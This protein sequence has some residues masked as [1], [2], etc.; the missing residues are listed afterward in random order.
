MEIT[1]ILY[2]LLS[3]FVLISFKLIF[4]QRTRFKNL[5]PSPPSLPIIGNFHQLEQPLHRTLLRLSNRFGPVF[6]LKFGSRLAVIVSSSS[7]VEECFTKNDIIFANRFPSIKGKHLLYNNTSLITSSYGDHWRNQRRI[8][9]IEILSTHRINSFSGVRKDEINRLLQ[10]L[11]QNSKNEFAKVQLS[12]MLSELTFNSVMRMVSGK[13]YYGD[14]C[15]VTD[16]EEAKKFRD[17]VKEITKSGIASSLA[18]FV[19]IIRWVNKSFEKEFQRIGKKADMFFQGLIDEHRNRKSG[20]ESTNTMIDHLLGLQ[21]SQ[22]DYY[23]DQIIKGLIMV[24]IIAGTDT[25]ACFDW[26][27]VTEEAIDMTEASGTVMAKAIPLEAKC[28]ARAIMS[29]ISFEQ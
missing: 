8:S 22:P 11:Y 29:N 27:R 5:P 1:L 28:R 21:E 20:L 19:P 9:S 4:P 2:T 25:S 7:A 12:P 17:L 6:S 3:L 18:E 15:D 14:D 26:E 24:L 16:V 10:K 23:T 13:R